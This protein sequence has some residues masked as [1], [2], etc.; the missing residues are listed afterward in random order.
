MCEA[1]AS[2]ASEN[3]A[4]PVPTT[5]VI[6]WGNEFFNND[7]NIIGSTDDIKKRLRE[8]EEFRTMVEEEMG[9]ADGVD[10]MKEGTF[11]ADEEESSDDQGM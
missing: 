7:L 9:V 4:I 1:Q 11:V 5:V 6:N 2:S 10:G 8:N 3:P